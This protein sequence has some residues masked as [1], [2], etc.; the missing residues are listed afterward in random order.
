MNPNQIQKMMKQAQ[1]MQNDVKK[2]QDEINEKEFVCSTANAIELKMKGNREI[3]S[4]D[5][6]KDVI[7]PEDK[8]MLEDL[9][10]VTF[11]TV[12]EDI[13]KET[14]SKMGAITGGLPF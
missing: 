14:E 7:D 1:Q 10:K 2:S 13:E 6:N 9:I 5:I 8:E 11:K 12:L 3:I 4:L